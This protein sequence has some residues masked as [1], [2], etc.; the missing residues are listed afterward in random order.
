MDLQVDLQTLTLDDTLRQEARGYIEQFGMFDGCPLVRALE[1]VRRKWAIQ[2]VM[3]LHRSDVPIR[4][5]Q[6]ERELAPITQ[7]ELTKRLREL[8]QT[9]IISRTIY[10]E[11][12]PRVEY[13]LTE[14]GLA[15]K[16]A[17]S[18]LGEW[19]HKFYSVSMD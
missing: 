4:F 18:V 15:F 10:P 12:P 8:E 17:L 5:N 6:L 14:S 2:I 3:A 16:Q 13:E 9:G 7:K 19:S 11:V 1:I